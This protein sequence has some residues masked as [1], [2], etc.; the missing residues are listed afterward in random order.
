[1]HYLPLIIK[2]L[3]PGFLFIIVWDCCS[4]WDP[5]PHGNARYTEHM[6]PEIEEK[7]FRKGA[8]VNLFFLFSIKNTT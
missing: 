4:F 3:I 1:M 7:D 8:Q 5:G 2:E 6:S